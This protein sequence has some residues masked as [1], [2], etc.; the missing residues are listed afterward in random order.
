MNF[1]FPK[2]QHP[3]SLLYLFKSSRIF[4]T[5]KSNNSELLEKFC[6]EQVEVEIDFVALP[7][8]YLFPKESLQKVKVVKNN[9]AILLPTSK[10]QEFI[11]SNFH[12]SSD[13]LYI[14][15]IL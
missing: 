5:K 4:V 9:R 1:V 11:L 12:F 14:M 3:F 13:K 6:E 8:V 7:G 2:L 15:K 10:V